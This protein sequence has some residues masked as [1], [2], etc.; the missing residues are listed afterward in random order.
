[1]LSNQQAK[2]QLESFE[3]LLSIRK[4]VNQM[5][6]KELAN[7]GF[8]AREWELLSYVSQHEQTEISELARIFDVTRTL[9]SK[10]IWTLVQNQLVRTQVN[11]VDRR[12]IKLSMTT[13]G[14]DR[15]RETEEI[16]KRNLQRFAQ[17]NELS[18]LNKQVLVLT[19]Q[20]VKLNNL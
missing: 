20:L 1:M 17:T 18:I 7:T 19:K 12:K 4:T 10:N 14:Q 15:V 8:S 16:I 5:L 6:V 2:T 3:N 13:A 11:Q 9:I